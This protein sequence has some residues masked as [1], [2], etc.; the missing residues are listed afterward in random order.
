M[1]GDDVP[2]MKE[3]LTFAPLIEG[4]AGRAVS[5]LNGAAM[6]PQKERK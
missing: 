2:A 6:T 4:P 5:T 1:V 3:K